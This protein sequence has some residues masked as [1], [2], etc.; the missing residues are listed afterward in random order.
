VDGLVLH[1]ACFGFALGRDK[2]ERKEA[3]IKEKGIISL[4]LDEAEQAVSYDFL[5]VRRGREGP[6]TIYC[7]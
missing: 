3:G 4:L 6:K 5:S 7:T 1:V 2:A